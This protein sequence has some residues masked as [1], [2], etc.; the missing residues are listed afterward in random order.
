MI[1]I[2]NS[3]TTVYK[4]LVAMAFATVGARN[5]EAGWMRKEGH[6]FYGD[7]L[8]ELSQSF[9]GVEK[10]TEDQ[11]QATRLFSIYEVGRPS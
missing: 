4:G 1:D 10:W 6:R 9:K 5:P 3:N 7:A 11:L 8:H 2:A